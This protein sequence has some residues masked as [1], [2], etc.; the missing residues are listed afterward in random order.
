MPV[1][2]K[3]ATTTT[4][5]TATAS[6]K[7]KDQENGQAS[8]KS[9]SPGSALQERLEILRRF[10]RMCDSSN[11]YERS[12]VACLATIDQSPVARPWKR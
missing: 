12:G 8:G 5:Q 6:S 3:P 4:T 7:G 11:S 1:L 10:W 9:A 2:K